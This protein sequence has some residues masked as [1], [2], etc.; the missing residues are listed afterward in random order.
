LI[1]GNKFFNHFPI[2]FMVTQCTQCN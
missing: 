1:L 2:C